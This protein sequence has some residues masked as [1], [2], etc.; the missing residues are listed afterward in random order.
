MGTIPRAD[1]G[2]T[3]LGTRGTGSG[4]RP[5]A[6]LTAV[7]GGAAILVTGAAMTITDHATASS[8]TTTATTATTATSSSSGVSVTSA[9]RSGSAVAQSGGS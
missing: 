9:P 3:P 1:E 6:T 2:E 5:F 7:L 4:R 8:A